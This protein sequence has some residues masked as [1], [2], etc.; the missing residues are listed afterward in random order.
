M[1]SQAELDDARMAAMRLEDT[2]RAEKAHWETALT[3]MMS[4][5]NGSSSSRHPPCFLCTLCD[6]VTLH[7]SLVPSPLSWYLYQCLT[8]PRCGVM[9]PLTDLI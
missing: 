3:N 4:N 2:H 6:Q 1:P 8:P 9:T 5:V 7:S